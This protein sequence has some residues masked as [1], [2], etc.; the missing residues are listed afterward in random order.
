VTTGSGRPLLEFDRIT[1]NFRTPSGDGVLHVLDNISFDVRP[2]Q[3]TAIVGP[4]GC[5]KSTLLHIAAGLGI[6][7][8]GHSASRRHSW[9]QSCAVACAAQAQLAP[10][11]LRENVE[12]PLILRHAG[13][14]ARGG[15]QDA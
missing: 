7:I 10:K 9:K 8:N 13:N 14:S 3:F 5:G 4:S 11:T 12:L 2:H 15:A 6:S 1:C